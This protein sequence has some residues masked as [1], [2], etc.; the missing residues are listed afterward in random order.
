[1]NDN[2]I[3]AWNAATPT[4]T[5]KVGATATPA[6]PVPPVPP[7]PGPATVGTSTYQATDSSTY[8]SGGGWDSVNGGGGQVYQGTVY[9]TSNVVYGSWFYSGSPTELAGRTING[10]TFRLG[11]RLNVGTYNTAVTVHLYVHTSANRPGGDVT[12]TQGPFDVTIQPGQG[13][14]DVNFPPATVALIA[15]VLTGGG[16]FSIAGDPYAGVKGRLTQP[17]SGLLTFN[18]SR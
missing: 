6:P 9:G 5:G 7:P 2:V 3:L 18:W 17:D 4:V 11:T 14:L 10:V 13:S 8:W 1:V 12:R 16:G 15:P